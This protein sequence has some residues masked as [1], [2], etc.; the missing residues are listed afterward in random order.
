MHVSRKGQRLQLAMPS[1]P[2]PGLPYGK[3]TEGPAARPLSGGGGA[4]GGGEY[5]AKDTR[6]WTENMCDRSEVRHLVADGCQR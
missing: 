5:G 2:L 6:T 4:E 1:L 3:H